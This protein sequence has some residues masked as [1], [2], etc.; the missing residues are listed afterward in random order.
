LMTAW[1]IGVVILVIELALYLTLLVGDFPRVL[2]VSRRVVLPFHT[3]R[4]DAFSPR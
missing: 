1:R 4:V 3:S 2:R